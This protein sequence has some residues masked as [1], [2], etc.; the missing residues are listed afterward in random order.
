V[1]GDMMEGDTRD[2]AEDEEGPAAAEGDIRDAIS[3][4]EVG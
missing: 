1:E 4:G 2:V 3:A